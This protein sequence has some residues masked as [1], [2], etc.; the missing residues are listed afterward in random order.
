MQVDNNL[1]GETLKYIDHQLI[2]SINQV[3][4]PQSFIHSHIF[5]FPLPVSASWPT[6][7]AGRRAASTPPPPSSPMERTQ[8]SRE[9]PQ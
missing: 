9:A 5:H 2:K 7:D 3:S 1:A 6:A 4:L 8:S